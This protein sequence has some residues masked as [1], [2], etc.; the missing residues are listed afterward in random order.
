MPM[1]GLY[2]NNFG[3]GK[4]NIMLLSAE[5]MI[6]ATPLLLIMPRNEMLLAW[7]GLEV[8]HG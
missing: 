7:G 4:V 1:A 2:N 3:W 6:I 5:C 8:D